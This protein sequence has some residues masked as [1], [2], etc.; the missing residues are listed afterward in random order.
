MSENITCYGGNI[1]EPRPGFWRFNETTDKIVKC[2]DDDICPGKDR[3]KVGHNG[4]V[5]LSCQIGYVRKPLSLKCNKC[6]T[7][8]GSLIALGI[9]RFF[10]NCF[11]VI[12]LTEI[13]MRA[14]E[15]KNNRFLSLSKL[16]L[17]HFVILQVILHMEYHYPEVMDKSIIGMHDIV[18]VFARTINYECLTN[19]ASSD[20]GVKLES[21]IYPNLILV[22]FYP[23]I[24]VGFCFGL[25][26][27]YEKV[28]VRGVD[29]RWQQTYDKTKCV[30]VICLWYFYSDILQ[31]I[32][33]TFS[34]FDVEGTQ[35]LRAD[36]AIECWQG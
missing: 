29:I 6:E 16:F 21:N 23:I 3:C 30:T 24:T 35:R 26:I 28:M 2:L 7:D 4:A 10:I 36:T 20:I 33:L 11:V 18:Q 9:L 15:T 25:Y 19:I 27:F 32:L 8:L 12:G 1:I 14:I 31:Y 5:C 13:T 17:N 22:I 34:C